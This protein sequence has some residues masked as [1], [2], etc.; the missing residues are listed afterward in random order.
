[1]RNSRSRA[2][3]IFGCRFAFG[4][5]TLA[6]ALRSLDLFTREMM[7]H[8]AR[9]VGGIRKPAGPRFDMDQPGAYGVC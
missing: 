8:S 1:M 5:L 9:T 6:D 7:P 4:D 2:R 3:I